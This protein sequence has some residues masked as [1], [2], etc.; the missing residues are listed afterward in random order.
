MHNS[1]TH[2]HKT[3]IIKSKSKKKFKLRTL[4]NT[5][6]LI[7]FAVIIFIAGYQYGAKYRNAGNAPLN[8]SLNGNDGGIFV[9]RLVGKNK[10]PDFNL[11]WKIWDKLKT[12]YIDH[13]DLQEKD[14]LYGSI[15]GLVA[16][17]GDPYTVFLTPDENKKAKDDL[18]GAFEGVGIQLGYKE[19]LGQDRL[20]VITPLEGNPA[21]KAGVKA[22]D[23]IM[24]IDGTDTTAMT[25]PEAVH[26][27]RGKKGT[28][29]TLALLSE[30]ETDVH[31]VAITRETI[32]VPSVTLKWI[33]AQDNKDLNGDQFVALIRVNKFGEH[34]VQEWNT[35]VKEIL[36]RQKEPGFQGIVLDLRGNPG[37]LFQAAISLASDL[38]KS[39]V[40]VQ[41]E[42]YLGKRKQFRANGSARLVNDPL[43]VL[44]NRGSASASEILAGAVRDLRGVKL[45]GERTFGKGTVQEAID[46]E[47]NTGL[48][49]TKYRWLLPSGDWINKEGIPVDIEVKLDPDHPNVD[50]QL[51]AAIQELVK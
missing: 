48:H 11:Y 23:L 47:N 1:L 50:T 18:N 15:K 25:L 7:G 33:D 46:L 41:Q 17:T 13:E 36:Q 45:I 43:V 39:G 32:K 2:K 35:K 49:I 4:R 8:I 14:M 40:V 51:Q 26:L 9:D 22:G 3:K 30:K 37:G 12:Q 31:N 6:L 27:I 5:F 29:V 21:I 24:E 38:V 20:A 16:S 19:Y 44:V 42:D 34:T 10:N 28:V